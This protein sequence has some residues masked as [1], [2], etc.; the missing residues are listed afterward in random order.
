MESMFCHVYLLKHEIQF[1]NS[2]QP[3]TSKKILKKNPWAQEKNETCF[4]Y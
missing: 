4:Q 2:P 3:E 1:E